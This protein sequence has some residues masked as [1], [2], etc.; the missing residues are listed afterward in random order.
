MTGKQ[1]DLEYIDKL[2]AALLA[3]KEIDMNNF[4]K[5]ALTEQLEEE[6]NKSEPT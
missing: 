1:K 4:F 3:L 6:Q 2:K 5:T